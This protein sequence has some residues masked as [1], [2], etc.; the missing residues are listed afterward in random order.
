MI[1]QSIDIDELEVAIFQEHYAKVHHRY[2]SEIGADNRP[3]ASV[4]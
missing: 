1:T 3:Q 4:S 2:P